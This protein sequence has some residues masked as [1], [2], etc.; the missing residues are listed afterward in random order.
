MYPNFKQ[1]A[2]HCEAAR[3][4]IVATAF[5]SNGDG[6]WDSPSAVAAVI[7]RSLSVYLTANSAFRI[8]FR[9]VFYSKNIPLLIFSRLPKR[10]TYR[11][12]IEAAANKTFPPVGVPH[13]LAGSFRLPHSPLYLHVQNPRFSAKFCHSRSSAT[14]ISYLQRRNVVADAAAALN[15]FVKALWSRAAAD[16]RFGLESGRSEISQGCSETAAFLARRCGENGRGLQSR[17]V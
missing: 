16:D 2:L 4:G 13:R 15:R 10:E 3:D 17:S 5:H 6:A 14:R 1:A 12:R 7:N 8:S 11:S 9:S